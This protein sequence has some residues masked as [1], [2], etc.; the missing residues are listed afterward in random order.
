VLAVLAFLGVGAGAVLL[1]PDGPVGVALYVAPYYRVA[2]FVMGMLLAGAM[3]RGW[4]PPLSQRAALALVVAAWIACQVAVVGRQ[5]LNTH[6]VPYIL[7]DLVLLLP[8]LALIAAAAQADL[9]RQ[10]RALTK[11]AFVKLGQWSFAL[12]LLHFP[13]VVTA[14]AVLAKAGPA[15]AVPVSV[16]VILVSIGLS[17]LVFEFF[18]RPVERWLRSRAGEPERPEIAPEIAPEADRV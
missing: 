13:I 10:Q 8:V 6:R 17:A 4:R 9:G 12:Y 5:G 2:E 15:V 1:F 7:A 16:A 11:P 14:A 3:R 18:E